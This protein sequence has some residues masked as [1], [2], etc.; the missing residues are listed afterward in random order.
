MYNAT[1]SLGTENCKSKLKYL[2]NR[3]MESNYLA[4]LG[5]AIYEYFKQVALTT[6][7]TF[8][9]L[10]FMCV[11]VSGRVHVGQ[12]EVLFLRSCPPCFWRWEPWWEIGQVAR[13]AC[14]WAPQICLRLPGIIKLC[15][16]ALLFNYFFFKCW[17]RTQVL[18]F[19]RQTP[20]N[21]SYL[22]RMFFSVLPW[23]FSDRLH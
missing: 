8:V 13:L 23:Q 11:H 17:N 1:C 3:T 15:P 22:L 19:S 16:C 2:H 9:P 20:Y 6:A 21:L 18:C 4:Y 12:P 10:L 7:C 14:P 5:G